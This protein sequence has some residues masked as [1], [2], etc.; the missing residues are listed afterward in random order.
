MNLNDIENALVLARVVII[1]FEKMNR[2]KND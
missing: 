2:F 1:P